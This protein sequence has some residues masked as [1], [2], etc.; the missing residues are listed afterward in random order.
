[1]LLLP[2]F[3]FVQIFLLKKICVNLWLHTISQDNYEGNRSGSG[4]CKKIILNSQKSLAKSCSV[5]QPETEDKMIITDIAIKHRM[6]VFVLML[7]ILIVGTYSYLTLPREAAPV[8]TIPSIVVST[9]Y[10]GVSPADIETLVTRPIEKKLAGLSS[11]E[12]MR[13]VSAEGHS[14]IT[15]EFSTGVD[16]D[17]ALLLA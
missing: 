12:E 13:S 15:I 11:V 5:K 6:T 1:L 17:D 2:V 3:S 16:I 10:E 14:T 4:C 8:I 7:I 9:G